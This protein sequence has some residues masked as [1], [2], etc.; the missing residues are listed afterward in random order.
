MRGQRRQTAPNGQSPA[1]LNQSLN[2]G[3][4]QAS[5]MGPVVMSMGG[6]SSGLSFDHVLH[7]LQVRTR[8]WI[9]LGQ[10]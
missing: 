6:K 9:S 2:Q 1:G 4:N 7:K 8:L 3:M 5:Q 10:V